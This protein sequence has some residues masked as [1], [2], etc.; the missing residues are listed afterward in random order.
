MVSKPRLKQVHLELYVHLAISWERSILSY[1][2]ANWYFKK[3]NDVAMGTK[4]G[5]SYANLF[6]S[7]V[8]ELMKRAI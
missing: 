2:N 4:M 7:Y 3:V 5:P 6:L 8:Q 1:I